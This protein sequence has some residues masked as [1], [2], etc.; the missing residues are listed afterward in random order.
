MAV[1][2]Q[3]TLRFSCSKLAVQK[4]ILV[5]FKMAIWLASMCLQSHSSLFLSFQSVCN[6]KGGK[7]DNED[8]SNFREN[9]NFL[10]KAEE[11]ESTSNKASLKERK[12]RNIE[13]EDEYFSDSDMSESRMEKA[14]PKH[15]KKDRHRKQ[16][17]LE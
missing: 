11:K 9:L 15:K 1:H 10:L 14:R 8:I 6:F 4:L 7:N 12:R 3:W 5:W 13:R 2:F 17:K 16:K